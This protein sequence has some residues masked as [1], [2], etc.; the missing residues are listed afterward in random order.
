MLLLKIPTLGNNQLTANQIV[1]TIHEIIGQAIHVV[2][3]IPRKGII[4][5]I[6]FIERDGAGNFSK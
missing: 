3:H 4:E 1:S 5:T 2:Q 6:G